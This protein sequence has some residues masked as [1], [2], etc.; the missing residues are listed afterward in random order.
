MGVHAGVLWLVRKLISFVPFFLFWSL[1]PSDSGQATS[2]VFCRFSAAFTPYLGKRFAIPVIRK[3]D[4]FLFFGEIVQ[5]IHYR[6]FG[7][8]RRAFV[9]LP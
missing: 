9:F 7:V 3:D 5:D 6:F 8:F 2:S 1:Y 4:R